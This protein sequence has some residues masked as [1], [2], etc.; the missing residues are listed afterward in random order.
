VKVAEVA[1]EGSSA[2]VLR[3][4]VQEIA[5]SSPAGKAQAVVRALRSAGLAR[6]RVVCAVSRADA[7]VKRIPVPAADRETTR[8]VLSFEA[9]QHVPFP[10]SEVAWDFDLTGAPGSVLLVAARKAPLDDLRAVVAQAGLKPAAV[11]VTSV[12]AAGAHLFSR[13][14]RRGAP[15]EVSREASVLIELG[16]GPVVVNVLRAG[17][18]HLSRPLPITGEDLTRAFAED[19]ACDPKTA[20]QTRQARGM[21]ALPENA[22]RVAGWMN[23]LRGEVERSLLAAAEEEASLSVEEV[24]ATGG[25]WQTPG[26]VAAVSRVLGTPVATFPPSSRHLGTTAGEGPPEGEE[27]PVVLGTAI[28]L[29]LQGLSLARGVNLLAAAA[30]RVR[31]TSRRWAGSAVAFASLLAALGLGTWRFVQVQSD[32]LAKQPAIARAERQQRETRSLLARERALKARIAELQHL[33]DLHS[34]VLEALGLLSEKAPSGVWLTSVSY[35]PGRP[36]AVQGKALSANSVAEL[37]GAI[38][39]RAALSYVKQ[40]EGS[41]DFAL[42]IGAGEGD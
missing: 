42:T 38:G 36:V 10:L 32:S 23:T 20:E 12:A 7:T 18:L 21:A 34:E 2:R 33:V 16:S 30:A 1:R 31:R 19:M 8:R 14:D 37:I 26:L 22:R 5:D 25:G 39:N 6:R 35:L 11:S 27:A 17:G 24:V 28:G 15:D 41:A 4:A 13:P 29:A 40:G 3:W 9:Q